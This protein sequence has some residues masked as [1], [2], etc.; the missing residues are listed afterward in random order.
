V[1]LIKQKGEARIAAARN[2]G[3]GCRR[4]KGVGKDDERRRKTG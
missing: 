3:R 4:T 2:Q 1:F